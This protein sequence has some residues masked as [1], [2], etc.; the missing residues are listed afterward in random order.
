MSRY[1]RT[2]DVTMK[3]HVDLD[4]CTGNGLC[5]A[6]AEDVFEVGEDGL[7]HLFIE[8][9]PEDRREDMEEAVEQCPTNAISIED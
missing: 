6:V 2:G 4:K 5:E 3:M 8:E 9:P 7:A 1:E